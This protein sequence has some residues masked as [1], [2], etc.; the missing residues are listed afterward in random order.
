MTRTILF[1][2]LICSINIQGQTNTEITNLK[3]FAKAYGYVKYF[4]PSDE[5]QEI[6]WNNLAILGADKIS[7]CNSK[8]EVVRTLNKVF[9]PIAPAVNFYVSDKIIAFDPKEITPPN[10]KEYTPTYWQHEGV[11]FGM[12]NS[13]KPYKSSRINA[14]ESVNK[15]SSFGNVISNL[16]ASAF[17]GKEFKFSAWVK[18]KKGSSGTGHLWFRVDNTDKSYG[19]FENMQNN[20]IVE[21]SWKEY[22]ITGTVDEKAGFLVFGSFL[23]GKGALYLD[24]IN[25]S[26]KEGDTWV[27]VPLK[28][29][30][31]EIGSKL[32]KT[33]ESPWKGLGEGYKF[34]MTETDFK[35][36]KQSLLIESQQNSKTKKVNSL[37]D[38]EVRIGEVIE[39]QIGPDIYCQVPL[40]L[41]NSSNG[42]FPK[43]N[44]EELTAYQDLV[45]NAHNTENELALRLGNTINVY[46]VFQHF[47]PYF[48]VVAV[49]WENELEKALK[50][51][52]SDKNNQEHV[53]SLQKFTAPLKD[54]HIRVSSPS[55][56][57]YV[58][59]ISWEWIANE[60]I[61]TE[62]HDQEIGIR[63]G[64]VVSKINGENAG[65]YFK[66]IYSRISAGNSGWMAYRANNL[67][68]LGE[69]NTPISLTIDGR[70]V[71][72]KRSINLYKE[73]R[74]NE[75]ALPPYKEIE[76]D[77]HYL[78]LDIVAMDTITLLMPKLSTAKAIICDLRGYPNA[79]HD[80][81]SHLLKSK[82]T[83]SNWMNVP[84]IVYPD[85]EKEIKYKP[86]GW[87][88]S[89]KKPYLGDKNIVFIIDG[90]AISYAES[91]MGYIEGYKLATIV[92]QPTAGANGNVN[93]FR[94]PGNIRLSWTGM[95]VVKL[96]G[97]QHHTIGILPNVLVSKTKQGVIDGKDEFLEKALEIARKGE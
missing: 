41:Y 81:I 97:D 86:F 34:S 11:S 24:A 51:S 7:K 17:L 25:L 69:E 53:I 60:L 18:L 61:I 33:K 43:S 54:G 26:I 73:G 77:I 52:Y 10:L 71:T 9:K 68:L 29:S 62:V 50:R 94:L 58:P 91:Y 66:E 32:N 6:N 78:N 74:P 28:N 42:T 44:H 15:T 72:L 22:Q 64:T 48:D 40:A 46:N 85:Q 16:E 57:T 14:F 83:V 82:D 56:A 92:G 38:T 5:A 75:N 87:Q 30:S 36:G 76:E 4:H 80:L 8:D 47:Y 96:N 67:S 65:A 45:K 3:T 27:T 2:M 84:Q 1:F 89:A 19:F 59:P 70:K 13:G 90:S 93:P 49:N 88:M 79:N 12:I 20:P 21:N 23:N 31:F 55:T 63:P 95:K 35:E 39:K 37:F